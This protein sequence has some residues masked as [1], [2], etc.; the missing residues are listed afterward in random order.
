MLSREFEEPNK[1]LTA[2]SIKLKPNTTPYEAAGLQENGMAMQQKQDLCALLLLN[3]HHQSQ[4]QVLQLQQ[5]FI[6]RQRQQEQHNQNQILAVIQ[7]LQQQFQEM[8]KSS[9]SILSA[10]PCQHNEMYKKPHAWCLPQVTVTKQKL[11]ND[12]K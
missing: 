4:Q 11:K 7:G 10:M 12:C 2:P 5:Q 1:N 3:R 6:V 9:H 8:N